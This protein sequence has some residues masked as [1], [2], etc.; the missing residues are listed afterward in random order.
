MDLTEDAKDQEVDQLSRKK[1]DSEID[2]KIV[3]QEKQDIEMDHEKDLTGNQATDVQEAD[4]L[5]GKSND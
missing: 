5:I 1:D 4:Q 3:R 2:Q